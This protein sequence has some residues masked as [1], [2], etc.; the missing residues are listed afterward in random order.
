MR[1]NQAEAM[2]YH[3]GVKFIGRAL[4]ASLCAILALVA[5]YW[6]G[7]LALMLIDRN[8]HDGF[9]AAGGLVIGVVA[10]ILAF[11]AVWRSTTS[12]DS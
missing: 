8:Y 7:S 2:K 9:A 3:S 10:A 4:G 11:R 5:G 12:K 6:I 1:T